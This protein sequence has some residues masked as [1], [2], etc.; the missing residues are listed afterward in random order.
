MLPT[1][2]WTVERLSDRRTPGSWRTIRNLEPRPDRP[3]PPL[4]WRKL[5]HCARGPE[6]QRRAVFLEGPSTVALHQRTSGALRRPGRDIRGGELR[7][8]DDSG[9]SSDRGH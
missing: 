7:L 9:H 2:P 3:V 6:L 1:P 8:G 4:T 5:I